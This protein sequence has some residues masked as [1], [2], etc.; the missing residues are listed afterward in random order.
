MRTIPCW[1]IGLLGL[2]AAFSAHAGSK[3]RVGAALAPWRPGT[4]D[5]HHIATGRGDATL[6]I[7]PDGT[8]LL[9][10]A[11]AASGDREYQSPAVPDDSRRP[12]QWIG[13][14]VLRQL[15]ATGNSRLDYFVAS[16]LHPDHIGAVVEDSPHSPDGSYRLT[17]VSDV[18][19]I[20]PIDN[21]LDR[22]FPRYDFPVPQSADF[23]DN[24]IR[25]I[26]QREIRGK[27]VERLQAGRT[28]QIRLMH[29]PDEH[30]DFSIRTIAVGG[31][32]W[33]GHGNEVRSLLPPIETLSAQDIPDENMLSAA[34]HIRFGNF[35]YYTAGDLSS[36]TFDGT[37]PWRDMETPAAQATGPVEVA[38]APHHGLFDATSVGSVL[39]LKPRLWVIQSWHVSHPSITTLERIYNTRL[40]D[41][42][43][44]VLATGLAPA[45]RIVN[46]R[47]AKRL[48]SQSGHIVVRV[49]KGGRSYHVVVIDNSNEEDRVA[50]TFGPFQSN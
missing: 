48:L 8:S 3:D 28:D 26:R 15:A 1:S 38:V 39:A 33:T 41:G 42:P 32:V 31:N 45:N 2:L 36:N 43:R 44:D 12:G 13:R 37:M 7:A 21:V 30:D 9:V 6:M 27:R 35:D 22:G 29:R 16:H 50:A 4:M 40:Y 11:G 14:Y 23:A 5:I 17:G 25:F 46:N 49:A 10:D 18:A 47:L 19:E 24:Y 20:V 34:I